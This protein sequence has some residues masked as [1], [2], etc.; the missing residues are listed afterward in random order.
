[1]T[2]SNYNKKERL[3]FALVELLVAMAIFSLVATAVYAT[4]YT[5]IK[6]YHRTQAELGSNQDIQ[7]ILDRLSNE[8]RNCLNKVYPEEDRAAFKADA[9]SLSFYA[10]KDVYSQSGLKK[11]I[12]KFSYRFDNGKLFKKTQIDKDVFLG[13]E[14]FEEEE[15]LDDIQ[16]LTFEYMYFKKVYSEGEDPYEWKTDWD[17]KFNIP[18]AVRVKLDKIAPNGG[19]GINIIRHIYLTRG[20]VEAQKLE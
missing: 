8:L 14:D 16:S 1:M 17:E 19:P 5:S 3:G 12:T 6:A 10:L 4:L 13:G 11:T 7:Q 20:V 15:L 18:R 2:N 9:H